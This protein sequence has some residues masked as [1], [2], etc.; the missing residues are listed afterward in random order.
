[1]VDRGREKKFVEEEGIVGIRL[2]LKK[3]YRYLNAG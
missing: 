3:E 1:M 2:N